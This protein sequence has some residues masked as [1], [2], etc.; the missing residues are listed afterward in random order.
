MPTN[1]H[2]NEID[3]LV[4][5]YKNARLQLIRN[6]AAIALAFFKKSFTDQGFTDT[7]LKKWK[8]RKG[9][10]RNDGRAILVDRAVLKRG[11]RIKRADLNQA[12]IGVDSAIKYADIH[13][14]GGEI[15]LTPKMRRF[16]WVMYYKNGG[17]DKRIR[18]N[19]QAK[20]WL[21]LALKKDKTI[22]IPQRQFIGD[23]A[24]LTK[25][26]STYLET[27]LYKILNNGS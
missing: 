8:K 5:A 1:Q 18:N 7:G 4:N 12:V 17:G 27:E 24:T 6:S 15:E 22:V 21:S 20:F 11:I 23:S 9:G 16:F 3:R 19:D 14:N 2:A 13:N 26:I 10:A 25:K